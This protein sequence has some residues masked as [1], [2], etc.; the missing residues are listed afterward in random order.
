MTGPAKLAKKAMRPQVI[1]TRLAAEGCLC[2]CPSMP[3]CEA[4]APC[5]WRWTRALRGRCGL[6]LVAMLTTT[7]RL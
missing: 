4:S 2:R 6:P 3:S 7:L 5:R 1:A